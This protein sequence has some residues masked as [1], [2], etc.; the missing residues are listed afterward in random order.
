MY[1]DFKQPLETAYNASGPQR[2]G[3]HGSYSADPDEDI[4]FGGTWALNAQTLSKCSQAHH[5]VPTE[6]DP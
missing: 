5:C 3:G 4:C 2:V 6:R 1:D